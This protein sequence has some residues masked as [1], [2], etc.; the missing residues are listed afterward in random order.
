MPIPCQLVHRSRFCHPPGPPAPS[1]PDPGG[2][3][4]VWPVFR[5]RDRLARFRRGACGAASGERATFINIRSRSAC[6]AGRAG[7]VPPRRGCGPTRL[8]TPFTGVEARAPD[9]TATRPARLSSAQDRPGNAP[10]AVSESDARH[11]CLP[12]DMSVTNVTVPLVS[13]HRVMPATDR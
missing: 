2:L 9:G 7:A 4:Q 6:R 12:C 8:P 11:T 13:V 10:A 1:E 5:R 3:T